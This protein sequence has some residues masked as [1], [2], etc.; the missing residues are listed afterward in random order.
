MKFILD[1]NSG[2]RQAD[3]GEDEQRRR[4]EQRRP[5][6]VL[7]RAVDE[8]SANTAHVTRVVLHKFGCAI[9]GL[10]RAYSR[11]SQT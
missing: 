7:V 11:T 2:L 6:R 1:L 5:S 4:D 3:K 9:W 8:W 10:Q